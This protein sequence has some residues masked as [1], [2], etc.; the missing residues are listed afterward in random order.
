MNNPKWQNQDDS[1]RK[2]WAEAWGGV[3]NI[4]ANE[5]F[6][7]IYVSSLDNIWEADIENICDSMRST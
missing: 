2:V 1:P 3:A 4:L 7:N 6:K 5:L